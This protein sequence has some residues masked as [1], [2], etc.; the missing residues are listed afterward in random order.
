VPGT[1]ADWITEGCC[2]LAGGFGYHRDRYDLSM[3]VGELQV[4][5]RLRAAEGRTVLAEGT[6]CRHQLADGLGCGAVHPV[7]WLAR[8]LAGAQRAAPAGQG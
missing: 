6:S 8:R 2:G 7:V 5:P 3:A 4:F 1:R